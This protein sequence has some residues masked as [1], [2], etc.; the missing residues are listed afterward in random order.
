MSH[1]FRHREIPA[2]SYQERD[3]AR[4]KPRLYVFLSF[5][6]DY[7]R[8]VSAASWIISARDPKGRGR[9]DPTSSRS[10]E[11]RRDW[12]IR[13][14][15]LSRTHHKRLMV[16]PLVHKIYSIVKLIYLL[17]P[18]IY[19]VWDNQKALHFTPPSDPEFRPHKVQS[20]L[21]TPNLGHMRS[22]VAAFC[23]SIS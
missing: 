12:T 8:G 17:P 7:T 11:C 4:H 14:L 22:K 20:R 10:P 16:F 13:F 18:L 15:F 23:R 2:T 3:I 1:Q 21:L 5:S 9:Y 6:L 19:E